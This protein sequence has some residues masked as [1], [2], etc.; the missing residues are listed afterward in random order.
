VDVGGGIYMPQPET[1]LA[2]RAHIAECHAEFRQLAASSAIKRLLG[3][4]YGAE[5]SRVPKGFRADHPAAD[6]L[7]LKQFL[8]FTTLDAGLVTTPRLFA[9]V[10]KRFRAMAPILEFL[11]AP[12]LEKRRARQEQWL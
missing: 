10:E 2:V 11:N 6:L 3:A 5:L 9:E 8:L 4:V 1:L 12:L 7:R